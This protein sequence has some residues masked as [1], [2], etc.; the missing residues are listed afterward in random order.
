M[1]ARDRD[2]EPAEQRALWVERERL[3]T[4]SDVL[5]DICS[6]AFD[7]ARQDDRGDCAAADAKFEYGYGRQ[8]SA[9]AEFFAVADACLEGRWGSESVAESRARRAKIL[10]GDSELLNLIDTA[11]ADLA[12]RRRRAQPDRRRSR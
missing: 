4:V 11:S 5:S 2:R 10:G 12:A 6:A 9:L 1:S 8:R 3:H 7:T